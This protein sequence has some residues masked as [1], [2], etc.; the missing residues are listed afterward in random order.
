MDDVAGLKLEPESVEFIYKRDKGD[1]E[2]KKIEWKQDKEILKTLKQPLKELNRINK[3]PD[4]YK[5]PECLD[6]ATKIEIEAEKIQRPELKKL[7]EWLLKY[8]GRAEQID[9][10]TSLKDLMKLFQRRVNDDKYEPGEL[11][12]EIEKV[13]SMK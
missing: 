7:R 1:I 2:K 4:R 11:V 9:Q 12:E 6:L 8:A 10:N 5:A 3:F 13:L